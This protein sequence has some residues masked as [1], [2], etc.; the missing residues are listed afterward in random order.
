M[1]PT[2]RYIFVFSN[3]W[4]AFRNFSFL[5]SDIPWV[6]PVQTM[7]EDFQ[8]IPLSEMTLI[9]VRTGWK[10]GICVLRQ[11]WEL[12]GKDFRQCLY[13]C[14]LPKC[15]R[16][17]RTGSSTHSNFLKKEEKKNLFTSSTPMH[18]INEG[19]ICFFRRSSNPGE[20]WNRCTEPR[21]SFQQRR[22]GR[23][24]LLGAGEHCS[25]HSK[26]LKRPFPLLENPAL[27]G[28]C[29]GKGWECSIHPHGCVASRQD[30][31]QV[32]NGEEEGRCSEGGREAEKVE[33][34][35]RICS[36]QASYTPHTTHN[37]W[38]EAGEPHLN[39]STLSFPSTLSSPPSG[40][41]G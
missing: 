32:R 19:S 4:S 27:G 18:Q 24:R 13:L 34:D 23:Q 9:S 37:V 12:A 33:E 38:D 16:V 41:D 2:G 30:T 3:P 26:H 15:Q 8:G 28:F 39:H 14:C 7:G 6:L 5:F 35:R 21:R 29:D 40:R 31:W 17:K 1:N 20:P 11:I 10:A 22:R 36:K 25:L